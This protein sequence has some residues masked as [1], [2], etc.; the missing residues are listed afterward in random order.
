MI[1]FATLH[2]HAAIVKLYR[3]VAAIPDGIAR[4]PSEVTDDYVSGFMQRAAANGVELVYE[5]EGRIAG[6]IHASCVGIASLAHLLTD[7][8][9]AIHPGTQGKGVGR[10]LF[11]ALLSHVTEAMPHIT[12]VELFARDSNTRARALYASLGFVEEGR[13]RARVNNARSEP[14]TDT[15]MG[16][17][18]PGS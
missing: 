9:I 15:V 14:E 5:H 11:M 4:T 12:R 10:Q 16:W 2:D 3:D 17:L 18:R 1:R 8:T 7:L 13:L 6:E